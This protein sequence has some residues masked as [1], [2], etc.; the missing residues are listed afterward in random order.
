MNEK[1]EPEYVFIPIIKNVEINESNN[2]I[3]IKIGSNVKEIPIAK[4]N[5]ITNI[6]DKGNI[7]NVLVITGY[8]VDET[9]GLLVPTLDP[10]DY[11]KG[12]LVASNISQSNKD[13]QQKTGQPT[14]QNN[15]LADFLKIKLPVDKL[16]IIRK[17]NISKGELVIYIPYKTTLDPNRVIETKSVR[18]DDNDKTVDKIYNVLSKIY[19]KSNIKKEDIKDL[20]N[21]FTLELK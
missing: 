14:Q 16:Y 8:A 4:S 21:Y 20:F 11:V 7:R 13:E 19:Q 18:I 3:I 6:D 12:I 17:S 2:G 5:H 1:Q 15:Q 9:T 10:C